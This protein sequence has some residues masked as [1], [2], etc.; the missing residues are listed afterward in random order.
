MNIHG[1]SLSQESV[2]ISRSRLGM[3]LNTE[4]I[5]D[6]I[7]AILRSNSWQ[8]KSEKKQKEDGVVY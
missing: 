5:T 6:E 4:N 8:A 1:P 3:V 7:S 2:V